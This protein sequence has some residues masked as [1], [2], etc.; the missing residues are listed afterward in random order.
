M[1]FAGCR[2]HVVADAAAV[3]VDEEPAPGMSR[4]LLNFEP[5]PLLADHRIHEGPRQQDRDREALLARNHSL[6]FLVRAR[7]GS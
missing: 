3:P 1:A 7:I 5:D 6:A 4:S 2:Q